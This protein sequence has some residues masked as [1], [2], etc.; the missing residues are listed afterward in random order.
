M[1]KSFLSSTVSSLGRQDA[2]NWGIS[3]KKLSHTSA[4]VISLDDKKPRDYKMAYGGGRHRGDSG[5]PAGGGG[6]ALPKEER[7]AV[8]AQG[9][10]AAG[11]SVL[12][13]PKGLRQ[14]KE[15]RPSS[16]ALEDEDGPYRVAGV[17]AGK[18]ACSARDR[19]PSRSSRRTWRSTCCRRRTSPCC[20]RG[21]R[22]SHPGGGPG[23]FGGLPV[24]AGRA[25]PELRQG[26]CCRTAV[27]TSCSS[28]RTQSSF[29]PSG[30]RWNRPG[31]R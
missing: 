8:P 10:P 5:G 4:E 26:A 31:G 3:W 21:C 7:E 14:V 17:R 24:T 12:L 29:S 13:Y 20:G 30:R 18:S 2:R 9:S 6:G 19:R 23:H 22:R 28:R 11:W 27:V 25:L 15:A 1:F 16:L